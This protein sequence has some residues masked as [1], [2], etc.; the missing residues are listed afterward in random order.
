MQTRPLDA[1]ELERV[2]SARS[3]LG[4]SGLAIAADMTKETIITALRGAPAQYRTRAK[5]LRV[6]ANAPARDTLE[7]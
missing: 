1:G 3:R 6:A 5:L 2:Q 4:V 7:G